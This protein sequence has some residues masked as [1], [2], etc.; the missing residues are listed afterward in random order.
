M[1]KSSLQLLCRKSAELGGN[2][3]K[4]TNQ[5]RQLL[6]C[7]LAVAIRVCHQDWKVGCSHV[8]RYRITKAFKVAVMSNVTRAD[9]VFLVFGEYTKV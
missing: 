2:S 4:L 7:P 5:L 8:P 3:L 6:D 1:L 9:L